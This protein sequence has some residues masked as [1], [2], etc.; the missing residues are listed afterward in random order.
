MFKPTHRFIITL[1]LIF[2]VIQAALQ[3]F[4]MR[5]IS[6]SDLVIPIGLGLLAGGL[7]GYGCASWISRRQLQGMVVVNIGPMVIIIL[8]LVLMNYL[9]SESATSSG[10]IPHPCA[11][12]GAPDLQRCEYLVGL[13]T[14]VVDITTSL[15]LLVWG[16]AYE[17]GIGHR[18]R[19][20]VPF[21][22]RSDQ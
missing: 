6:P 7:F 10:I 13:F 15:F 4:L 20:R 12:F 2:G 22:E 5:A 1:G 9:S 21:F 17:N 18:L 19:Y 14:I 16:V 3:L 11:V 8:F